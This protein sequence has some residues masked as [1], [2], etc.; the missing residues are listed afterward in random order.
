M[1]IN[2]LTHDEIWNAIPIHI[3]EARCVGLGESHI[4]GVLRRVVSGNRML[5]ES[6]V[7]L[8][9]A[10]L[11]KPGQA[12]TMRFQT[13][14]DIVQAV[15]IHVIDAHFRAATTEICFVERPRLPGI[16]LWV[17]EPSV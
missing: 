9:I 13:C 7:S 6:D 2:T 17:F 16:I 15:T 14:H 12:E 1:V 5:N 10:L 3:R 8:A 11:F 4:A